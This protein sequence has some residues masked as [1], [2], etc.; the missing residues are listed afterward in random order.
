M[1]ELELNQK[2]NELGKSISVL[3]LQLEECESQLKEEKDKRQ[4]Y[5]L[6][7]EFTYGWEIWI[8][9]E[10]KLKYSSSSC[11]D[12]TG[13][14]ANQLM[15][16]SDFVGLIVYETDK[17]DLK[18]FISRSLNQLILNKPHEFRIMTRHKQ[19]R[20]CSINARGVYNMQGRYL[21]IRASVQNIT[22][23]KQVLGKVH[24]L[25]EGKEMETRAKLRFKAD[26]E[27][28]EREL[29]S[30][31]LEL[32]QKNE[33]IKSTLNHLKK[34]FSS[35]PD[36]MISKL[37]KLIK[38]LEEIPDRPVDWDM[39]L[40]QLDNLHPGFIS[41]LK[42][43]HPNLT[44]KE[45]KLCAFLRLD[46]SSKEISGLQNVQAKSIEIARVR[47]RKKL[48]IPHDLRLNTYIKSI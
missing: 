26:L 7:S 22:H 20:W 48:K 27:F 38:M 15:Q 12:L 10:N 46:L 9:P 30:F 24:S 18:M 40:V 1:S 23:L 34:M 8:D 41:R 33:Y 5:E 43:K 17:K 11:Y 28:T 31:L 37:E 35:S 19:I 45:Y 36:I 6:I 25:S 21:G 47:L 3:K 39:L 29:V 2:I 14:S 4:F 32:S 13:F 44:S 42:I 16:A